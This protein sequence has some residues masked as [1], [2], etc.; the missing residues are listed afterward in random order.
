MPATSPGTIKITID[1]SELIRFK[2]GMNIKKERVFDEAANRYKKYLH[3]RFIALS[4]GGGGWAPLEEST[5]KRKQQRKKKH[6]TPASPHWILRET[7]QLL[8]GIETVPSRDGFSIGYMS[9]KMH[10]PTRDRK[11]SRI[12]VARLASIHH[13]GVG[14]KRR[15]IVVKP[16]RSTMRLMVQAIQKKFGDIVKDSKR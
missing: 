8:E 14:Q 6:G 4:A 15:P 3:S 10:H 13:F 5:I 12:T 2:R 9:R 1:L 7:N 16:D 11:K